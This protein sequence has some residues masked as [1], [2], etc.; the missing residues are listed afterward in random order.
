M[1]P[2]FYLAGLHVKAGAEV[3]D[4]VIPGL[5]VLALVF[6]AVRWGRE[7][8]ALMLLTGVGIL[9]AGLW[10]TDVHVAL[11]RQAIR[12]QA[13]VG[14]TTYHSSTAFVVDVVGGGWLWRYR[15][16]GSPRS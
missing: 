12:G 8:P 3:V 15:H 11:V 14:A 4:H 6:V 1:A 2:G 10:M 7:V 13:P 16:A 9:L 5:A